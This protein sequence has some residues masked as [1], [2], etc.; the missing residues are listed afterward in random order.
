MYLKMRK[1]AFAAGSGSAAAPHAETMYH[2][3]VETVLYPHH[4]EIFSSHS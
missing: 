4:L 2:E 3:I 1:S